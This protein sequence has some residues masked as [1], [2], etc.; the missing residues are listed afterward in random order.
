MG[1]AAAYSPRVPRRMG[2]C[3]TRRV[4]A[5][6]VISA[7]RGNGVGNSPEDIRDQLGN[8][9]TTH[10]L[11]TYPDDRGQGGSAQGDQGMEVGT[12]CFVK[13]R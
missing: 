5:V 4:R 10:A 6:T 12:Q 1:L 2:M 9:V 11:A 3:R 8:L 7:P 13:V